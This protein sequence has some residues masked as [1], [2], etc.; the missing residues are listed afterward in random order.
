MLVEHIVW[1]SFSRSI[2]VLKW[3]NQFVPHFVIPL[4]GVAVKF[5]LSKWTKNYWWENYQHTAHMI[6]EHKLEPKLARHT[7]IGDWWRGI[8]SL[9][10]IKVQFWSWRK[11]YFSLFESLLLS[12]SSCSIQLLYPRMNLTGRHKFCSW[13]YV[14]LK[15][16]WLSACPVTI[17]CCH[18]QWR[19]LLSLSPLPSLSLQLQCRNTNNNNNFRGRIQFVYLCRRLFI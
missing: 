11:H 2:Q 1:I 19:W 7:F 16:A 3:Q 9:N 14:T 5:N 13:W 10:R 15:S 4:Y 6:V 8:V 17:W 18:W 12:L